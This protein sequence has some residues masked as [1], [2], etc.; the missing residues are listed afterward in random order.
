MD[1]ALYHGERERK[2]LIDCVELGSN[3]SSCSGAAAGDEGRSLTHMAFEMLDLYSEYDMSIEVYDTYGTKHKRRKN[4]YS[5]LV[6]QHE[7]GSA[8]QASGYQPSPTMS[9]QTATMH[10]DPNGYRATSTM[11]YIHTHCTYCIPLLTIPVRHEH[12]F[13]YLY[14]VQVYVRVDQTYAYGCESSTTCTIVQYSEFG[15]QNCIKN[16]QHIDCSY[17]KS[18]CA[19]KVESVFR[20]PLCFKT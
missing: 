7:S 17:N 1:M 19:E 12:M 4:E 8:H 5:L 14:K 15:V 9:R 11:S 3:A 13:Y 6:M 18:H 2:G 20:V 16:I 10:A